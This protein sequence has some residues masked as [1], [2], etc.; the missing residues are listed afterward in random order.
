MN[1]NFCHQ[2][3]AEQLIMMPWTTPSLLFVV[4]L[5]TARRQKKGLEEVCKHCVASRG[6]NMG[7]E[8]AM[9]A[10]TKTNRPRLHG[11][12]SWDSPSQNKPC[13]LR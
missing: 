8:K 7:T 4:Q 10:P 2:I 12:F 11:G 9:Y 6:S 1:A 13:R 5:A 3:E